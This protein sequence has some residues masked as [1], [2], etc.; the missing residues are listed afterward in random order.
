MPERQINIGIIYLHS[1]LN[2]PVAYFLLKILALAGI[3]NGDLPGTK[4]LYY[5]LSY[6]GLD[7][8]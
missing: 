2:N 3:W 4:P 6:P 1:N 5:Q 8:I 7:F